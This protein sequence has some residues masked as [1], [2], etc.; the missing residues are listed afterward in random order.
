MYTHFTT[1]VVSCL[2]DPFVKSGP[3]MHLVM[4]ID[5]KCTLL[6]IHTVI[7]IFFLLVHGISS[8][9]IFY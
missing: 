8:P 7:L 5:V 4:W 2:I 6:D 3:A 1:V 9:S